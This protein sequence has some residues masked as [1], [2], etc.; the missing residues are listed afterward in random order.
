MRINIII[1]G[2]GMYSRVYKMDAFVV[3]CCYCSTEIIK[4]ILK[5]TMF[6]H[7]LVPHLSN[8]TTYKYCYYCYFI[9]SAGVKW[10]SLPNKVCLTIGD[11]KYDT[12]L[13]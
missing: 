4:K 2:I 1:L 11:R 5:Y 6:L 12:F 9:C 3:L 10:T 7:L 8:V 13:N